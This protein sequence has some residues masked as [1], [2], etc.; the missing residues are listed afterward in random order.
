MARLHNEPE[1]ISAEV[2]YTNV[3]ISFA[4]VRQ[5]AINGVMAAVAFAALVIL[6]LWDPDFFE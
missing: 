5:S 4:N 6:E 3:T 2:R 1:T